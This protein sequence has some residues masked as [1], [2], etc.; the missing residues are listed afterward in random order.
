MIIERDIMAVRWSCPHCQAE[1]DLTCPVWE[2]TYGEY[3]AVE[4]PD[5]LAVEYVSLDPSEVTQ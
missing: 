2:D 5:C 3:L 4:C 1:N